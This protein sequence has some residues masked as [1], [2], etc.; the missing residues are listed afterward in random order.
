MVASDRS[1]IRNSLLPNR[2]L[3]FMTTQGLGLFRELKTI[4]SC[5]TGAHRPGKSLRAVG[6][7]LLLT[8]AL[9]PS[10]SRATTLPG[11]APVVI[12]SG[13]FGVDGDLLANT[14]TNGIGD[15]VRTNSSG[16]GFVLLTNGT[17][18]NPVTSLHVIDPYASAVDDS[19]STGKYVDNPNTGWQ[20]HYGSV[21]DK[22]DIN[23]A[24]VH[25]TTAANGHQWA[26]VSGDRAS[27][28]GASY[29]DFE[30][31]QDTLTLTPT[32]ALGLG[33]F[34]N[35]AP[36]GG[37]RINDFLLTLAFTS[38]GASAD[39]SVQQWKTNAASGG[40]TYADVDI[41]TTLPPNSVFAAVS[42][43]NGSFVPYGALGGTPAVPKP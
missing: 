6:L 3:K 41:A 17:P 21:S 39:F 34:T 35:G 9:A 19:F 4:F 11:S 40:F 30:F 2:R 37:R 23:H 36:H 43:I 24:V 18:V 7:C 10:T 13:G 22:T 8:L 27:A 16:G 15:W 32:N 1:S 26:L 38:G 42:P 29:I 31:L 5:C 12:P 28:N 33:G 20:W 25:I 14:P